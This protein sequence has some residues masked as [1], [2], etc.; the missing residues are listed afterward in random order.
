MKKF[1]R[2]VLPTG[3]TFSNPIH[4]LAIGFGSGASPIAPGT[5]GTLVAIPI[6]L[7]LQLV[8]PPIY[9]LI[10]M[11]MIIVGFWIC[12]VADKAAGVHDHPSIV[13]DEIVGYLL[14]MWAVPA[15][16]MWVILG[17]LLF[18]LFDIWK[19]W[20]IR[21]INDSVGGGIG[22]VVD[23]LMAAVY[24]WIALHIVLWFM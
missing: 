10:L 13:W 12:D 16:W 5:M 1:K 17:F 21:W 4:F 6:Y 9:T 24:A 19:P 18:R 7:L 3:L 22:V 23:D 15:N 20:P 14:T 11:A 2:N 8:S